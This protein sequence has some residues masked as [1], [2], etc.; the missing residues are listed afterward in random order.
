MLCNFCFIL[1]ISLHPFYLSFIQRP[2]DN[3]S[4]RW[5]ASTISKTAHDAAVM[6]HIQNMNA[7]GYGKPSENWID[8]MEVGNTALE[9]V[10]AGGNVVVRNDEEEV[11]DQNGV[12]KPGDNELESVCLELPIPPGLH[13]SFIIR[14]LEDIVRKGKERG[15]KDWQRELDEMKAARK[16]SFLK[17]M[18]MKIFGRGK[19]VRRERGTGYNN[20]IEEKSE[21]EEGKKGKK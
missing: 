17:K 8:I 1:I 6:G 20:D 18:S 21:K 2:D 16:P 5:S 19:S 13:I 4:I 11:L 15:R 10:C 14:M 9:L 12:K 3:T 7:R